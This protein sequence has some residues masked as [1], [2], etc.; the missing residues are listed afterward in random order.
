MRVAEF[1]EWL[2]TVPP[3]A[4]VKVV[5]HSAGGGYYMQGG[6]CRVESFTTEETYRYGLIPDIDGVHFELCYNSAGAG[7]LL[8]GAIDR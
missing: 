1:I 4:E 6:S 7:V 2:K 8:L 5:T 3:D